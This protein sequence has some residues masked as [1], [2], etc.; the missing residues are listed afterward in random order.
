MT[1]LQA[2]STRYELEAKLVGQKV[3]ELMDK[4]KKVMTE[5]NNLRGQLIL[6]QQRM[7][8]DSGTTSDHGNL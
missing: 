3:Q 4:G 1:E 6:K 7:Q 5:M 2:D 8:V